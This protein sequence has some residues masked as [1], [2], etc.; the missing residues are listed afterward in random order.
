MQVFLTC[1][2]LLMSVSSVRGEGV[3]SSYGLYERWDS[4]VAPAHGALALSYDTPLE[5]GLW[6][7]IDYNTETLRLNLSEIDLGPQ[8]R[9]GLGVTGEALFTNVLNDHYRNG[10]N[11]RSRSILPSYVLATAWL[12][13]KLGRWLSQ[14]SILGVRRWSHIRSD[15]T[16]PDLVL[17][18]DAWVLEPELQLTYWRLSSADW[19]QKFRVFPRLNGFAMGVILGLRWQSETRDWGALDADSF[20]DIDRRNRP[21]PIQFVLRQWLKAGLLA[22]DVVRVEVQQEAAWQEHEDDLYRRQVG[23]MN[24]FGIALPGAPWAY[25][26]SGDFLASQLTTRLRVGQFIETGPLA[27]IVAL[28][29]P[30]RVGDDAFGLLAG[31]GW[32]LDVRFRR[33][34]IDL[35]GGHSPSLAARYPNQKAWSALMSVGY[36]H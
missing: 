29:D 2:V 31:M 18:A 32:I 25:F 11:D 9:L 10:S 28:R 21:E 20:D 23:G 1:V 5:P 8:L 15:E 13:Y 19:H 12:D 16:S 17:P 35:R 6:L 24:P 4:N 22:S 26:Q 14:R 33:W 7:S 3:W 34:Q 30:D 27:S 36:G